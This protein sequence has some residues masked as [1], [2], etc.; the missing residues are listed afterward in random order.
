MVHF[1]EWEMDGTTCS[2]RLG[3]GQSITPSGASPWVKPSGNSN[4]GS[5]LAASILPWCAD[6]AFVYYGFFWTE[7]KPG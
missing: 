2:E 1:E 4:I 5:G 6:S 7:L 3:E